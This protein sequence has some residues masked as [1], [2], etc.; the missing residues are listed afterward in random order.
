MFIDHVNQTRLLITDSN[1]F[2]KKPNPI[3][4]IHTLVIIRLRKITQAIVLALQFMSF[5]FVVLLTKDL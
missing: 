2:Q 3:N 1:S 5:V 4:E